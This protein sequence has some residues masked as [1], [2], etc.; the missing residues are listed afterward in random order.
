MKLKVISWKYIPSSGASLKQGVKGGRR[1]KNAVGGGYGSY[2]VSEPPQVIV[3]MEDG[4][5]VRDTVNVY[6]TLKRRMWDA[7][8]NRM[9]EK[10]VDKAMAYYRDLGTFEA[11]ELYDLPELPYGM[12]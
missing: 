7:G 4:R 5:G 12:F 1:P 8:V 3:T 11:D 2:L 9:T 10:R 6:P